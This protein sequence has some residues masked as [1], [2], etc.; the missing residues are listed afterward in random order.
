[1]DSAYKVSVVVLTYNRAETITKTLEHL[2]NQTM[3]SDDFE[4]IVVD[5][6]STDKTQHVVASIVKSVP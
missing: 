1:M 6:G 5:D 4:V 2:A 3:N